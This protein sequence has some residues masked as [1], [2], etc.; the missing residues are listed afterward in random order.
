MTKKLAVL[1]INRD[2]DAKLLEEL[3]L[4]AVEPF[5]GLVEFSGVEPDVMTLQCEKQPE[6][7]PVVDW[8]LDIIRTKYVESER[9]GLVVAVMPHPM[10][11]YN[12][13]DLDEAAKGRT[14]FLST[15][16][17]YLNPDDRESFLQYGKKLTAHGLGHLLMGSKRFLH[18][19][20]P[21]RTKNGAYCLMN[22]EDYGTD[23]MPFLDKLG[24]KFCRGCCERMEKYTAGRL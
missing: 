16:V 5:N 6:E 21:I 15:H 4:A 12:I 1:R 7:T 24:M 23:V 10:P 17:P 18:H 11:H 2:Y 13:I 9:G 22:M 3:A 20:K 14:V 19:D 8:Q